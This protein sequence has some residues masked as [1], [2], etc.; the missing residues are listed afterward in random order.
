MRVLIEL[1]V[2]GILLKFGADAA[3]P[4]K[5]PGGNGNP[6]SSNTCASRPVCPTGCALDITGPCPTCDCSNYCT[7]S[8]VGDSCKVIRNGDQCSCSCTSGDGDAGIGA[9]GCSITCPSGCNAQAVNGQCKCVSDDCADDGGDGGDVDVAAY[10]CS[11]SC[12]SGCNALAVNG[13]CK[14]VSNTCA[15]SAQLAVAQNSCSIT[16]PSGCDALAINGKCKCVCNDDSSQDNV[17]VAQSSCS[18]ACYQDNCNALAIDGYCRC[19][20]Q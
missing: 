4:N 8:C 16:C 10:S 12:P 11:I 6:P 3:R 19:E 20:C 15:S 5:A 2:L 17:D 7:V 18:I 14:C 1:L 9:F 13:N